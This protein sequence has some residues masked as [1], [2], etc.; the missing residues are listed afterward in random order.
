MSW[1]S[2]TGG[3]RKIFSAVGSLSAISESDSWSKSRVCVHSLVHGM[4]PWMLMPEM[5]RSSPRSISRYSSGESV[6]GHQPPKRTVCSSLAH[7]ADS[8]LEEPPMSSSFVSKVDSPST[9]VGP[10]LA[11]GAASSSPPSALAF[12]ELSRA[13]V[14]S[15]GGAAPSSASPARRCISHWD[16]GRRPSCCRSSASFECLPAW[17]CTS[18]RCTTP[19]SS[20]SSCAASRSSCPSPARSSAWREASAT[21][22]AMRPI[23]SSS[24][25]SRRTRTSSSFVMDPSLA[26]TC[27]RR[28][29]SATASE[30]LQLVQLRKSE[31][32]LSRYR[33]TACSWDSICCCTFSASPIFS[34]RPLVMSLPMLAMA[35]S[36][37]S[38][39]PFC[40]SS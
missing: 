39:S 5:R 21:C 12:R 14:L 33:R 25:D 26:W 10:D 3:L 28:V 37:S 22:G 6:S 27:F 1:M 15:V 16:S 23:D 11:A 9:P 18:C 32:A 40:S 2:L 31:A 34:R 17:R 38:M 13:R 19:S 24:W 35:F 8:A 30:A 4:R 20:A 7:R 36:E 29:C